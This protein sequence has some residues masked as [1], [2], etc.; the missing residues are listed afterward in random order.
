MLS[1]TRKLF[2]FLPLVLLTGCQQPMNKTIQPTAQQQIKQLSALVAGAHYLQKNCQRAE[3]PD[4]AVLLKTAL[5][6]AASRHWD[7][8]APA[9]KLLGEQSQARYQALVKENETDKSMC[10]EL[11]LLMVDFVDEAQRNIK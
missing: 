4:D 9:Y 3:V 8:R 1:T 6:L 5:N 11:N 2:W 7:T 10:T